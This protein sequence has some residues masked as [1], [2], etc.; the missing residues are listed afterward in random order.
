LLKSKLI[1]YMKYSKISIASFI[2]LLS[3]L[4]WCVVLLSAKGMAQEKEPWPVGK[5]ITHSEKP[6]D[7]YPGGKKHTWTTTDEGKIESEREENKDG[8]IAEVKHYYSNGKTKNITIE[9]RNPYDGT[10]TTQQTEFD[11]DGHIT[12][13]GKSEFK[14]WKEDTHESGPDRPIVRHNDA[15]SY[16]EFGRPTQHLKVVSKDGETEGTLETTT[17]RDPQDKT[18]TTVKKNV[19][20]SGSDVRL[21]DDFGVEVKGLPWFPLTTEKKQVSESQ[22]TGK[23]EKTSENPPQ[24]NNIRYFE[25]FAGYAFMHASDEVVENLNGWNLEFAANLHRP[26]GVVVDFSGDYGSSSQDLATGGS[27]DTSLHRHLFLVGAQ[28]TFPEVP[29]VTPFAHILFGAALDSNRT[30][31][32]TTATDSSA[33]AFAMGVGG[34]LD[35]KI[36]SHVDYRLFQTDYVLTNFGSAVQNNFRLSTGVVV[37]FGQPM[38]WRQ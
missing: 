13:N 38:E 34:G 17:Y 19:H 6:S 29:R 18:G 28:F 14:T 35:F 30:T 8:T 7:K 10:K 3:L 31:I 4:F 33:T 23:P 21:V 12:M 37:Q 9:K 24:E 26:V 36:N 2:S 25:L 5:T 20:A 22:P 15:W 1:Y 16:D 32:G 27:I 11:Q